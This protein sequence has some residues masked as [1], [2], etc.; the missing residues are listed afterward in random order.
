MTQCSAPDCKN[1]GRH[2]FPKDPKRRKSWEKALRIKNFKATKHSVLCS[3]H[4]KADDYFGQSKYTSKC[5]S[6]I[7]TD[8]Q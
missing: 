2:I 3:A 1:Q 5:N 6:F 4:F 8:G 7:M